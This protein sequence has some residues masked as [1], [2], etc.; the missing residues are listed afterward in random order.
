MPSPFPA[1]EWGPGRLIISAG[2]W[3]SLAAGRDLDSLGR[4]NCEP[5]WA[6]LSVGWG[7]PQLG[8]RLQTR[9]AAASCHLHVARDN[10]PA[11]WGRRPNLAAG[12][13]RTTKLRLKSTTSG[14]PTR[15][16]AQSSG[17]FAPLAPA[18]SIELNSRA[19]G[20]SLAVAPR[21]PAG[22]PG[23]NK[24][25][26]RW[27]ALI[28]LASSQPPTSSRLDRPLEAHFLVGSSLADRVPSKLIWL[29]LARTA[30]PADLMGAPPAGVSVSP[31][32]RPLD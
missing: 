25:V 23:D 1:A 16:G 28:L 11:R 7:R 10:W 12:P 17:K 22:R 26:D 15:I 4:D 31:F 30:P 19:G 27:R 9:L 13:A 29:D 24:S 3:L 32:G 8:R 6:G 21:K 18:A 20:W 2:Q 14:R 5:V